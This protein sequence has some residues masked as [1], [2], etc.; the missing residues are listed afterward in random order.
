MSE[1]QDQS[2]K[3]E[4]P[5]ERK[6]Q[7]AREK[8]Q[9]F[10]SKELGA[11]LSLLTFAII[12]SCASKYISQMYCDITIPLF[13][14]TAVI[15]LEN[16]RYL[17]GKIVFLILI[18]ST[19]ILLINISSS[20]IQHGIVY[21]PEAL[22]PDLSRIS[23]MKGLKR[24]F[25]MNSIFELVKGIIK[26]SLVGTAIYLVIK[27]DFVVLYN[28]YKISIESII[29]LLM[30]SLNKIMII[31]CIITFFLGVGDYFYQR[32]AYYHKMKMTKQD[33]KEEYK[34][35][36]GNPEI[37]SKLKAMRLEKARSR[38]M[39]AVPNADV[40]ITNPTHYAIA[41]QYKEDNMTVPL[42][43]AKGQDEIALIIRE[44]AK[45]YSIPIVENPSLARA[46]YSSVEVGESIK[47]EHYQAVAEVIAYIMK[48]ANKKI[49]QKQKVL[50]K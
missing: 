36:E 3:T 49:T 12:I 19:F 6:L 33:V 14:H 21:S 32:Y 26:I 5:S 29:V 30:Q 13:Q 28:S 22:K 10:Y 8:G 44:I 7:E 40:I 20:I 23:I 18:P 50:K 38:M 41:L 47:Y 48:L 27:P 35:Q 45:E 1:E 15:D 17:L 39:A 43:I 42:V 46:L 31:V 24:I 25:S 4:E 16:L 11:F 9:T 37:K 2:S 34:K